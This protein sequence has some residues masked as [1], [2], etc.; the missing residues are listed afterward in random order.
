MSTIKAMLP[1]LAPQA[2]A[3][4]PDVHAW[5][6]ASAGTGK[7]QVLAARVLRLLLQGVPA[8]AILCITFTK[9]AAAEM[10]GRVMQRL[11]WWTRVDDAALAAE[12]AAIGEP[13]DL[14]S[15]ARARRLFAQLLDAPQGLAVQTIHALAQSLIG[16]FPVEAG[17]APGFQTLDD[18]AGQALRRRLLAEAIEA[19]TTGAGTDDSAFL[20]DLARLSVAGGERSLTALTALIGRHADALSA[21]PDTG[22]EPMLRRA[23]GLPTDGD[24]AAALATALARISRADI[25]RLAEA[26][27]AAAAARPLQF[28]ARARAWLAE[29]G[30][31]PLLAACFLKA[32]GGGY[33]SSF[34]ITAPVRAAFPQAAD[35]YEALAGQILAIAAEQALHAAVERVA[36]Q[37]RVARRL[38]RLWLAAKQRLGVVDYD[39]MIAAARRLLAADGAAAWV[40]YK[41][42]QR[43]DHVLVD[44]AQDTNAAQWDIIRAL[45]DEFFAGEGAREARRR[46]FVVGD[47]KQ[48]IFGFQGSDPR[49]YRD[50]REDFAML[51][52]DAG[53][54]LQSIPLSTNFRSQPCILKLVDAVAGRLPEGALDA[55]GVPP[56][57]AH[58]CGAGEVLMLPLTLPEAT[59]D[60]DEDDEA[61]SEGTRPGAV[62]I[63]HARQ[64][65][66]QIA[67]WLGPSPMRLP[68]RGTLVRPQ[69]IL[70][71]VRQRTAFSAA[72]VAA[73][74]AH[75]VAVAGVDRLKLSEPLAVADL[76]ALARFALQPADDLTLACLLVSPLIGLSH[77]Q[78]FALAHGRPASLWAA[79]RASDDPAVGAARD[80]LAELLSFADFTP[81]YE[82]LERVLSGPMQGRA[83]LLARLGP[84]AR[85][86]IDT[87]LDQALAFEAVQPPSLQGFLAWIEADDVEIKRDPDAPLDAVRLMTVH[88]AKGLQAPVVILADAARRPRK[89]DSAL[90]YP[91]D[92]GT[93]LPIAPG[94]AKALSGRLAEA[95]AAQQDDAM[96]EHWRLMYVA[97][98]R[99][100]DLLVIAGSLAPTEARHGVA[101]ESSWYA[102]AEAALTDLG[103]ELREDG[104]LSWRSGEAA[105]IEPETITPASTRLEIPDWVRRPAPP[106][107]RPS[108]PLSPSA[109]AE[110]TLA[111]PPAGPAAAAAARRGVALHALF[112][113]LPDLPPPDRARIGLALARHLAPDDDPQALVDEVLRVLEDP[114]YAV[115]FAPGGLAEAPIAA[116]VGDTVIAG[117]VDRLCIT[118]DVVTLIDYK[119]GRRVPTEAAAAPP[120]H[121]AQMAAYA[122]ALAR[123]FPGRRIEAALLYTAGPRLLRLPP[124]LLAAH[125]PH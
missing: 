37:L 102:V 101:H 72:L 36:A 58:R 4:D 10:Q 71:L 50:K 76:L 99:A 109:I 86:A 85:D 106:E 46:L 98:T 124:A 78:L 97:L 104:A 25:V 44:E 11:A 115:L 92:D 59:A 122:A 2:Q 53:S 1:L 49:I 33:A 60:A 117:Q 94:A 91:F 103:A 19:A 61:L 83:R 100:E 69:D 88:G 65:A 35:V 41:L 30:Q 68:G 108:R 96:K 54:P 5:V 81:P 89:P 105:A 20:D 8:R 22:L 14:A 77:D 42:D 82:F 29:P 27:E 87:V 118:D 123:I 116:V 3:A 120:Y 113:R 9:L 12:L 70:V 45:T 56:H 48:A 121:L 63:A 75:G 93:L 90:L 112:E 21:L 55:D 16:A 74:H 18:R 119:T 34:C 32:D 67:G 31:F 80:W 110:D 6:A 26:W 62:E 57:H 40:R 7:T 107:A 84:E 28:A 13:D 73:L 111:A 43:I 38:S 125:A 15:R 66:A 95:L 23:F 51:A 64:L 17:V 79:V 47:Y 114:D 39:D 52:Q 24:G